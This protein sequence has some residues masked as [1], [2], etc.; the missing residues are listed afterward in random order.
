MK[1]TR[2]ILTV[3]LVF[4]LAFML[5]SGTDRKERVVSRFQGDH[6]QFELAARQVL[7][8]GSSRGVACPE[9]VRSIQLYMGTYPDAP[10]VE[11]LFGSGGFGS[12]TSYW[13]LNYVAGDRMVGFQGVRSVHWRQEGQG[14]LF[15]EP[16]GDN[17]CY[18]ERLEPCWFYFEMK[19]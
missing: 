19:F 6:A 5:I 7:E 8:Q 2:R 3:V 13:G 16:E 17:I 14:T 9:G 15:Y 10:T 4:A 18:V 1:K 12:E 11:F